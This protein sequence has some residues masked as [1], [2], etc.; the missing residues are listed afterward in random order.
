MLNIQNNVASR[1]EPTRDIRLRG[2]CLA[3]QHHI[4]DIHE[5][6]GARDDGVV[7]SERWRGSFEGRGFRFYF[8]FPNNP[9]CFSRILFI[10]CALQLT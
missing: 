5:L 8:I 6:G 7:R 9:K 4:E 3:K 1:R 10:F 2:G